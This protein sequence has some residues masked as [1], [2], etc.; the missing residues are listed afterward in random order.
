[1][2]MYVVLVFWRPRQSSECEDRQGYMD[3]AFK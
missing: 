2:E 1:M 3:S